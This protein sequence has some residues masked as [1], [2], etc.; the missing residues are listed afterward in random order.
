M[1]THPWTSIVAPFL[2]T[3]EIY[4]ISERQEQASDKR[5]FHNVYAPHDILPLSWPLRCYNA[6]HEREVVVHRRKF[7]NNIC[8]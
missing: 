2:T 8:T 1:N 4:Q 7:R 6:C 3:V 5:Q